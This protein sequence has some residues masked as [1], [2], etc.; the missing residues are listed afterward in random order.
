MEIDHSTGR[1]INSVASSRIFALVLAAGESS[2]MGTPKQLLEYCGVSFLCRAI[3]GFIHAGVDDIV[4]VCGHEF[5][6]MKEHILNSKYSISADEF[7]KKVLIARNPDYKKGQ[8]SSIKAGLKAFGQ[9]KAVD[10]YLGFMIQLIDRPLVRYETFKN[11]KDRFIKNDCPILLPSY[12]LKR[13]HP[14]CFSSEFA[15]EI[16]S[17]GDDDSLKSILKRHENRIKYL[18]T[19]DEGILKNIDTPLE[20]EKI[21]GVRDVD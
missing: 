20:F 2:R 5:D 18:E 9:K 1:F 10:F 17:L 11:L 6:I 14:A 21:K 13:G 19:D 8:L 16:L 15:G 12:N 7:T 4:V 3:E